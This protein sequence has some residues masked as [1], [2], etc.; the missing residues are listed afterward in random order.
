M[1]ID[2]HHV[3]TSLPAHNGVPEIATTGPASPTE[4]A[5]GKRPHS[6]LHSLISPLWLCLLAAL[7]IRVWLAVRTHGTLDGDEALLGIQAEHILQ[8]E[9][10]IYFYGIPYFGSLEAYVAALIFAFFGPSVAALRAETTAFSLVLVA[11]TYW[12]ASL[13]AQAAR[14]PLYARRTFAT[15]AALVAAIPPLYDGIV[16]MRT[17]GGWI[18]TFILMLLLL[19]AAFRLTTRWHEGAS[20]RELALR[21]AIIG[22]LVGFG[23]WIYPLISEAIL[24][25]GL[26]ILIDRIVDLFQRIRAAEPL[27]TAIWRSLQGLLLA[28]VAIP[29]CVIGFTPGIIWGAEHNWANITFIRSLGGG[30]SIQRLQTVEKVA[31]MY[32]TCV[33]PRIISGATPV[34]SPL[35]HAIHSPLLLVGTFCIFATAALFIVSLV[36]PHPALVQIR[37][38]TALPVIFGACTAVLYCT[39]SASASILISCTADFGGHYASTLAL[40]LPFFFGT[41]FTLASMFLYERGKGSQTANAAS[42][43]PSRLTTL[44]PIRPLSLAAL[45]A[46]GAILLAYLCGQAATYELTNADEAFQSAYCTIAPANYGPIITYMEQEHIHYAWATNLLGYQISFETDNSIILADPLPLIH[47]SIAINRIPAYTNAVKNADRPALLVFV[48]H[49][50]PHPYLL[51]LLDAAHVTYNV[52][53]FPSQPGVDVMVVIPLNR[54]VSPLASKS[55]D[56]FYCAVH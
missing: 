28:V 13:L 9:R 53:F 36:W 32:R 24:A 19:V 12:L 25:A 55:L 15:V 23:M 41:V 26:W 8:G 42:A 39:S 2:K 10:P 20:N 34:E 56:I 17:G 3:V 45:I 7:I 16:E 48:K 33:A 52:A 43:T 44:T 37:R 38:L 4:R 22:F 46:L 35:L 29:A 14:L 18:E 51:R 30:W 47:P 6:L 31:S 40:A 50:D 5:E 27:L 49:G 11:V 21:W 1:S 54:T